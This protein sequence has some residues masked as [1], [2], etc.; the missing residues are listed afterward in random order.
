MIN[1]K[2][3]LEL[4]SASGAFA[5]F[6]WITRGNVLVLMYH[7]FGHINDGVTVPPEAFA[8]QVAYLNA[9]Y[10][11]VP[12]SVIADH[13]K[14]GE[15]LPRGLAVITV[16]DG[17]NDFYDA[18]FPILRK[19]GATATVFLVTDFVSQ[20]AWMPADRA[21]FL[22][23]QAAGGTYRLEIGRER[24]EFT[25]GDEASRDAAAGRINMALLTIP[26]DD[27]PEATLGVARALRIA[28][29]ATPPKEF[30]ALRWNEVREMAAAGI[31]FGSHTVTHAML[32]QVSEE[33]MRRE[34]A[35]SRAQIEDELGRP[36]DMLSYPNGE[37]NDRVREAVIQAGY[38]GAGSSVPGFNDAQVDPYTIR[39][40][41]AETDLP[42]F[43]Q[44]TSGCEQ[45]KYQLRNLARA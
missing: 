45:V 6:R 36:A 42:H 33:K 39:R 24:V 3:A 7:R 15:K 38:R 34:V 32:S 17:Y 12:L 9:H 25:L 22:T 27:R 41:Y 5:P 13:L 18:A 14:A 35:D 43:V 21:A 20:Q 2:A 19:V 10:R 1:K 8:R 30:G 28:L 4:I 37:M 16:D 29:P 40:I 23:A 11:I 31:E 44:T 26:H